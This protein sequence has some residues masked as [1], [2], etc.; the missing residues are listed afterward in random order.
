MSTTLEEA[1]RYLRERSEQEQAQRFRR[2]LELVLLAAAS[3]C[4]AV[5]LWAAYRAKSAEFAA[6]ADAV[7]RQQILDL[8]AHPDTTQLLPFL[9]EIRNPTERSFVADR[10]SERLNR[11]PLSH[12][13]ELANL[14]VPRADVQGRHG[15]DDLAARLAERPQAENVSLLT[16]TEIHNLK[17]EFVVRTPQQFLRTFLLDISGFFVC[18][19]A[20]HVFWRMRRFQGDQMLLPAIAALCG[21]GLVLMIGLRDPLRDTL[22]FGDFCEGVFIGIIAMGAFSQFDYNRRLRRYSYIFVAATALLGLLLLFFG[23]GPGGSDAKV[24][25]FHFEPVEVMRILIV[26]FLAGY[27]GENWSALRDMRAKST[28]LAKTLRIPRIDYVTPVAAGVA[29]AILLFFVVRDNGPALVIG[30]LFL[31]LYAIARKHVL[32]AVAGLCIIVAIFWV[33][34]AVQFRTVADRIEMWEAPWRNTVSGGDQ[35]AQSLWAFASGGTFG[36]GP[37]RGSTADIPAGHTD[38]IIATAGET[39]GFAGIVLIFGLYGFL[40]W[41]GLRIALNAASSYSY[42]LVSG[43]VL[44]IALQLILIAGG[45]V[46]LIPLSGVVS[47][48]LSAGKT[49]MIANFLVFAIIAAVSSRK[50]P[51]AQV[52]DFGRP[53]YA[54]AAIL[55]CCLLA[56]VAK[57]AYVQLTNPDAVIIRDAEVRY[58]NGALGLEYNPR[59]TAVLRELARGDVLDRNGLP[60]ATSKWDTIEHHRAAYQQLGVNIDENVSKTD[61]RYYPLGPEFFYLVGDMRSGLQSFIQNNAIERTSR[62]RLQGFNDHLRL[63]RLTDKHPLNASAPRVYDAPQYD[64]RELVPLVRYGLDSNRPEV[65]RFL[66]RDRNVT[67]S[68]DAHL[69]MQVSDILKR[70]LEPQHLKGAVVVMDPQTGELLAAVSYPWPEP[71][72]FALFRK[73]ADRTLASDLQDRALFGFYPPGSSFKIVTAMAALKHDPNADKETFQCIPLGDGRVGNFVGRSRRPVR[74]DIQDHIA[75]GTVDL[76]KGIVVSCNAFFAQLGFHLG[77][78]PLM[79]MAKQLDIPVEPNDSL[80]LLR[81]KLPQASYGQGDVVVTPFRM[82]RVAATIAN[83]GTMPEGKWILDNSNTRT[84]EN[85]QILDAASTGKIASAMRDVVASPAGTGKV[86]KNS[87]VAIAGKTGTAQLETGDAHAW[88]IGYAPYQPATA[89]KRVAFAV[90]VEHGQY[91]GKT[92]APIA[93]EVVEAALK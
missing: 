68:I 75:H 66:A 36:A 67:M 61:S 40:I 1:R 5:A 50:R 8:N 10:I 83:G 53:T 32:G 85:V 81:Q 31:V 76:H 14:S 73:N 65:K 34:H 72:Q 6:Y 37:G 48:F 52:R 93:G 33:A 26:L 45:I 4:I 3:V 64:Y 78:A 77:A 63:E 23:K 28:W 62:T 86:L 35:I 84:D 16:R 29:V 18:F 2:N 90:L 44:I 49:S 21:M 30:A 60:L 51:G 74:D 88:F 58:R 57:C 47:P 79:D 69:Q 71:W 59:L 12:V 17:P 46:G 13:G 7:Q 9:D 15:L 54:A 56:V 55:G 24:M 89:G 92:A 22:L 82:A 38:L 19:F 27:L 20:L 70:H 43:L 42:F 25:L 80:A 87:P 41:R 11:G 39:F 91:G